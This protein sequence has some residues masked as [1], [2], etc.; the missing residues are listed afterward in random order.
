M[1][2][3]GRF[4][5][6]GVV[7]AMALLLAMGCGSPPPPQAATHD[8]HRTLSRAEASIIIMD[9]AMGAGIDT[10]PGW[11]VDIAS[12]R[13]LAVDVR[14]GE[15]SYGIAWIGPQELTDHGVALPDA[16][17]THRLLILPGHGDDAD[18]RILILDHRNYPYE[19]DANRVRGG[20]MGHGEAEGR[21]RRD[22]R[23][24]LAHVRDQVTRP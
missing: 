12:E 9:T 21:L 24:F 5:R 4:E 22:V 16:D 10:R 11:K 20:A 1:G 3:A 15:S 2:S 13:P 19:E 23:D 7:G 18:A 8:T 14:I 17:P 6:S